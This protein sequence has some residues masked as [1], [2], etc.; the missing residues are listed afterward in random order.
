MKNYA[1]QYIIAFALLCSSALVFSQD[2][3]VLTLS[4]PEAQ[5]IALD[6]NFDLQN[7]RLDIEIAKAQ[8]GQT[9][10]QGLPQINGSVD[11]QYTVLNA[12]AKRTSGDDE[13]GG[14]QP[15]GTVYEGFTPQQSAV[16]EE[17]S[18]LS[19]GNFFSNIGDAFASKHQS[20]AAVAVNQKLFDG[21]Y[22]LGLKAAE[23]YVDLARAQTAS[24]ERNLD[25]EVEKAYYGV[26]V[27]DENIAIVDKNIENLNRLLF[28]TEETYEAGFIEQLDVDRLKLSLS[29]LTN[30][31]SN[32]LK[33]REF[34]ENVLKSV[35]KIPLD[36]PIE[37]TQDI[38]EFEKIAMSDETL[39]QVKDPEL[40]PEFRVFEI[41]ENIQDLD[42]DR[43]KKGRLPKVDAFVNGSYGYQGNQFIFANGFDN[44]FP[45]LVAGLT[46]SVPIFDGR[47]KEY[48]IQE[49][50]LRRDKIAVNRNQLMA[51]IDIQI[52][53]ALTQFLNAKTDVNNQLEN[54]ALAQKIYNTTKIKYQEGV[55]SSIEMNQAEQDLYQAQQQ[56]ISA[57][58]DLLIAKVD[59]ETA[60]GK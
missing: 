29:T 57:L 13:G 5:N 42:I 19:I 26:L 53:N 39:A 35:L 14:F 17:V 23:V 60:L 32:L 24:T 27:A 8:V 58:Y 56:Y 44:W 28:E 7:Q 40:W 38:N 12:F 1:T 45:N 52:Q 20:T 46:I 37:L 43:Y 33:L 10:A 30:Q 31:K 50:Q 36:T 22:L 25:K 48:Q 3:E 41:Q 15:S 16:L 21:V 34:N 49:A 11:Y 47:L 4:L 59:L 2:E 6:N 51:N 18:A 55:G 9:K 54:I